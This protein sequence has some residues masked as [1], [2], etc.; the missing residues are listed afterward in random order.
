MYNAGDKPFIIFQT[1]MEKI[2]YINDRKYG[3]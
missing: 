1:E 2:I 3:I